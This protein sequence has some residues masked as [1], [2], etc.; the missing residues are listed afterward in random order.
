MKE[1]GY[2]FDYSTSKELGSSLDRIE[3]VGDSFFN[4]LIRIM[5]TR[6]MNEALYICTSDVDFPELFHYGLAA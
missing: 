6:C 5:T 3:K 4:K 1:I 2:Q